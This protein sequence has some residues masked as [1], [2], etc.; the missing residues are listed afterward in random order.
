VTHFEKQWLD[1]HG[2]FA[3]P[4]V[5]KGGKGAIHEWSDY[6]L[7]KFQ[8]SGGGKPET[9]G[10]VEE[11]LRCL[12]RFQRL[13]PQDDALSGVFPFHYGDPL[14]PRDN[15]TEFAL[16]PVA[17]LLLSMP[18]SAALRKELEPHLIGGL[19]AI[20]R[21]TVCPKY[22][23]ICL[24]QSGE[25]LAL[26]QV[27]GASD[28]A[29][30]RK[31]G[32][33][34][35]DVA[36]ARL[37]EWDAY[38]R[39]NGIAEYDSPTYYQVDLDALLLMLAAST[40]PELQTKVRQAL[41]YFWLDIGANYFSG[42][43]SLAGAHSR[44]YS[45]FAG[46][47][48]L[49]LSLYLQGLR[50]EP[51]SSSDLSA[52]MHLLSLEWLNAR[53]QHYRPPERA[54]C[55]ATTPVREIRSRFGAGRRERYTYVAPDFSLGSASDDYGTS[56]ESN[57]DEAIRAEL[58]SRPS[59][60]AI[61]VLPDYLDSPG[62]M[63]K[64]GDFKKVTHLL[65]SPVAAQKDGAMLALLR[66]EATDPKY[67]TGDG[68]P[69]TPVSLATNIVIPADADE[70]LGE[71]GPL[72]R[73]RPTDLGSNPA[74]VVRVGTGAV[75]VGVVELGGVEC[76]GPDG[77]TVEQEKA[78]ATFK[79]LEGATP[80]HGPTARLSLY[81]DRNP[82]IRGPV[83]QT[84]FARVALLILGG[85]CQENGCATAWLTRVAKA[86]KAATRS[87]DRRTG[88]WDVRVRVDAADLHVHR[89]V[90]AREDKVT[91][92]EVDG[93]PMYGAARAP[94]EVNGQPIAL[95]P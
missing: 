35:A 62:V 90:H 23:N 24:L 86:S 6:A 57:Q 12:M 78:S 83:G 52:S 3:C 94:L 58:P 15:P 81:H 21:H 80:E 87:Y 44:T 19:D 59:A 47:G 26:G 16:A 65:M 2:G 95:E 77:A 18:L 71:G 63:V 84:C 1:G 50:A 46:Q 7:A 43:G 22:T 27:L 30:A 66:I 14:N 29:T 61:V 68:R 51:P 60:S 28:D 64:S 93:R 74:L 54:L 9:L 69:L 39:A 5:D 73:G 42:R 11:A 75:G 17:A 45:F 72:D 33:G 85:R 10:L 91:A 70:I 32:Q 79:P 13:G 49:A 31:A 40:T 20:V 76:T 92:C 82:G 53:S 88:D 41:D 48:A 34:Y 56:L 4:S 8:L 89:I 37:Y 55:L 38:T 25:L 67:R 36:R